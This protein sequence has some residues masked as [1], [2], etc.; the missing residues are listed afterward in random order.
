MK[1]KEIFEMLADAPFLSRDEFPCDA[2]LDKLFSTIPDDSEPKRVGE[3][4]RN[5]S[6]GSLVDEESGEPNL[7]AIIA[8]RKGQL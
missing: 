2:E 1:D 4:M 7:I 5:L 6:H 8:R 3:V